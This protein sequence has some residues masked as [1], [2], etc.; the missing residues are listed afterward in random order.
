MLPCEQR[1]GELPSGRR[2]LER[3]PAS[4]VRLD[5]ELRTGVPH[6]DGDGRRWWV[7]VP[8]TA[9]VDRAHLKPIEAFF[10]ESEGE[11]LDVSGNEVVA[12]V[13][14]GRAL[15][16]VLVADDRSI[17]VLAPPPE[18]RTCPGRE[19]PHLGGAGLLE[20]RGGRNGHVNALQVGGQQQGG[21]VPSHHVLG[22]QLV[23]VVERVTR[24]V[25]PG[26]E[27]LLLD[28]DRGDTGLV[29]RPVVAQAS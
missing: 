13:S 2:A 6:A 20:E 14:L 3:C 28:G 21:H 11:R 23:Q 15:Q 17:E 16:A 12:R 5:A 29:E 27:R 8:K 7:P 9:V 25:D 1:V 26:I 4:H 22:V 18:H 24:P 19:A 10:I